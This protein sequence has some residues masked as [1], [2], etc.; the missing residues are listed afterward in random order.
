[1]LPKKHGIITDGKEITDIMNNCFI[2]IIKNLR[3]KRNL[4]HV[5]QP[6]EFI[7]NVF[8]HH[9]SIQRIKLANTLGN[10]QFHFSRI[11]KAEVKKKF[12]PII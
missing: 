9:K 4:I 7:I 12:K 6:L 8:R 10:D 1:M 11:A 3:L 2:N 5:S